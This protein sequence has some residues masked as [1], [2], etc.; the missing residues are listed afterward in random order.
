MHIHRIP[1]R[2]CWVHLLS[3]IRSVGDITAGRKPAYLGRVNFI[4]SSRVLKPKK[5]DK[6]LRPVVGFRLVAVN[7][8][9]YINLYCKL[10]IR[11]DQPGYEYRPMLGLCESM[12]VTRVYKGT[13]RRRLRY[14]KHNSIARHSLLS[15]L[16]SET[17]IIPSQ[18]DVGLYLHRRGRTSIKSLVSFVQFNPFKL[19]HRDGSTTKSFL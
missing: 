19:T 3:Q 11:R 4:S 15:S 8:H 14:K 6:G 16:V 12:G 17:P 13:T 1:K 5:I 7:R 9:L 2:K 18:L 10:G